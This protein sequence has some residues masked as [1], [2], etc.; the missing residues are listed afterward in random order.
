AEADLYVG[1]PVGEWTELTVLTD[2]EAPEIPEPEVEIT[3]TEWADGQYVCGD[4]TVLQTRTRTE[5]TTTYK[6]IGER[7]AYEVV[8]DEVTSA[9]FTE[10]PTRDLTAEEIGSKW[11]YDDPD[12]PCFNG[13][14]QPGPSPYKDV[15]E[16][17]T[18]DGL[19]RGVNPFEVPWVY[20][21]E[22]R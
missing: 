15:Y 19:F 20:D 8:V 5:T 7:G 3:Y 1:K 12:A 4:T 18:C 13:P 9:D 6:V 14:E 11:Q 10:E 2:C 22:A 16:Y 17:R 21:A